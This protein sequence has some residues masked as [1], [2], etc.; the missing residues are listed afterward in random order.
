M[1]CLC[2]TSSGGLIDNN[3]H[4]FIHTIFARISDV[5]RSE[6]ARL[7]VGWSVFFF[8]AFAIDLHSAVERINSSMLNFQ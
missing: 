2:E 6:T 3:K 1:K 5:F 7:S 4:D 8:F